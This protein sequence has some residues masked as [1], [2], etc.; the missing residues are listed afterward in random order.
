ML[1]TTLVSPERLREAEETQDFWN[2][3][4]AEFLEKYPE[5]FVAVRDGAVVA[6]NPD[7]A[8]LV[9][10]LRDLEL[11]PRDDVAI[12]FITAKAHSLIL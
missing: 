7:L 9:Y 5:Q 12:N 3:H 11:N 1:S 6:A 8:F 4:Y 10:E 2:E